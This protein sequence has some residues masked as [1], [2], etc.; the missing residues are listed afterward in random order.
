VLKKR[1]CRASTGAR[2]KDGKKQVEVEKGGRNEEEKDKVTRLTR[3]RIDWLHDRRLRKEGRVKELQRGRIS[4][5]ASLFST[6]QRDACLG[7]L[8][9]NLCAWIFQL[10]SAAGLVRHGNHKRRSIIFMHDVPT[11][12]DILRILPLSSAHHHR[13][14]AS[15]SLPYTSLQPFR[16]HF[17][18]NIQDLVLDVIC[19]MPKR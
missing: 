2:M 8:L 10:Y 16:L 9:T 13:V 1:N 7:K 19:K 11:S 3:G 4:G 17:S 18:G 12:F 5:F 6:I 14:S 15:A